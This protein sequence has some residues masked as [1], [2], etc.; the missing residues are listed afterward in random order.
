MIS[1][2]RLPAAASREERVIQVGIG[3]TRKNQ[4]KES[5]TKVSRQHSKLG[6]LKRYLLCQISA[7]KLVAVCKARELTQFTCPPSS[8]NTIDNANATGHFDVT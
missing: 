1:R 5:H 4:F 2:R 6:Y 7:I 3:S 8:S